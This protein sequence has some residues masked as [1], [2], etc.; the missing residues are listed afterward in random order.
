MAVVLAGDVGL[1]VLRTAPVVALIAKT[2]WKKSNGV[3]RRRIVRLSSG[4][5]SAWDLILDA[6]CRDPDTCILF[7]D[8]PV[9]LLGQQQRAMFENSI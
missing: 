2:F 3:S 1:E 5:L 6:S 4:W 8:A 9:H 7:V